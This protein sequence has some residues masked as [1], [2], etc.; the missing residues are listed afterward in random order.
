M[1]K[2]GEQIPKKKDNIL[3][4][5]ENLNFNFNKSLTSFAAKPLN[6]KIKILRNK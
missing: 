4:S 5:P 3:E 6:I 1:L 2:L